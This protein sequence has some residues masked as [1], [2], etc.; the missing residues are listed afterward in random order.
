NLI[1]KNKTLRVYC[2]ISLIIFFL[3]P[4]TACMVGPDY[5]RPTVTTPSQFK[6]AKGKKIVGRLPQQWKVATPRDEMDRGKWWALFHDHE[7]N[8]LENQLNKS[9]QSIAEAYAN[10]REA[11]AL[12]DE[13]RASFFPTLNLSAALTRQKTIGGTSSTS[14]TASTSTIVNSGSSSSSTTSSQIFSTYSLFLNAAWAPDFWGLVGRTVEASEAGA[15]AS[16]AL[17]ANTRLSM[18][19]SLAQFYFELRAVDTDQR[20]LDITVKNYK[21]LL[22]LTRNQYAAGVASEIDIVAAQSQLEAAQSLAINN[23]INRAIY[24]HAIAVLI[25]VP[26]ANFALAPHP[27]THRPPAIPVSVP[28][29]LLE[30]RPDIAYAERLMAQANAQI[31]V[32]K[33]AYF[34]AITLTGDLSDTGR[35]GLSRL[36]AVPALGWAY[37]PQLTQFLFDGGLRAATVR[38]AEAGYDANVA[39]YRQVVLAAFQNV[40]DNLATLRI[41]GKQAIVQ[42]LAAE[43]AKTTLKLTVNQYKAGIVP[44]SSVVTAAINAYAAEKSALDITGL[45]MTAAVGLMMALGGG[46]DAKELQI[47]V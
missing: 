45:R 5:K 4:L 19:G 20:L 42:N 34:P 31:G 44:Y 41:L 46:W 47:T 43:S 18:Q 17:L 1:P 11:R 14:G 39:S 15:L 13:A 23:K 6:E 2:K 26:P 8:K 25:G 35:G 9:N 40:E 33:A 24:E 36:I 32:A 16:A 7:L 37:G 3:V 22:Q 27:L 10:Y 29:A 21:K 28:S 12:V 30:R 38:A